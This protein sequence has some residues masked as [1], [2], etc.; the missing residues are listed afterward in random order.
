MHQHACST[1]TN[2]QR[3]SGEATT[4]S[5]SLAG[6]SHQAPPTPSDSTTSLPSLLHGKEK[7]GKMQR[8]RSG[9]TRWGGGASS[10]VG[11]AEQGEF[12]R[13]DKAEQLVGAVERIQENNSF[14]RDKA[15]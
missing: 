11:V 5:A 9:G 1:H 12:T 6:S 3:T 2:M 14:L 13:Q 10:S 4:S 8:I 7:R 15:Q